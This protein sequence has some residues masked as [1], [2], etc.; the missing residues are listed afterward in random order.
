MRNV[1]FTVG[2]ATRPIESFAGL[3]RQAE[4]RTVIDVR[5]MPRSRANPQ[6]NHDVL[7]RSL[8][9]FGIEYQHIPE[10]GGMRGKQ[11][12]VPFA[13]NAFWENRSFHNY[14]DYAM[15]A[16]FR[17]GLQKLL[18]LGGDRQCAI[19]CAETLWWRCH[20]RII[21]DY[22]IAAGETVFHIRGPGQIEQ[23]HMTEAATPAACG[24]FTYPAKV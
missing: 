5:T 17:S 21:A 15:G 23:A 20:R 9:P 10:L 6:F 14:A 4:V 19:M 11:K 2:H 12:D 7:S 8:G 3:L 24:V 1:F 22:L 13:V 16:E 18:I